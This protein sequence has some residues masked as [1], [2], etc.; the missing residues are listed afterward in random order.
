M[1]LEMFPK[2]REALLLEGYV[3]TCIEQRDGTDFRFTLLNL[4][5]RNG[6]LGDTFYMTFEKNKPSPVFEFLNTCE[7]IHAFGMG[8]I[9]S[10]KTLKPI[11]YNEL[12]NN[13]GLSPDLIKDLQDE[14][15]YYL[16]GFWGLR[17]AIV[18]GLILVTGTVNT[19][20]HLLGW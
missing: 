5:E 8:L 11:K 2:L 10:C 6:K 17:I 15:H 13:D 3:V 18:I 12:E 4:D 20:L 14:Y 1:S 9:H 7:E 19:A 16:V